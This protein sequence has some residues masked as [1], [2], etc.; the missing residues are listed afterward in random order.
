M[1]SPIRL[2]FS[3]SWSRPSRRLGSGGS[4]GSAGSCR[5]RAAAPGEFAAIA[6]AIFFLRLLSARVGWMDPLL[7]GENVALGGRL[8]L[9]IFGHLLLGMGAA[10][11]VA[12]MGAGILILFGGRRR[13]L[14]DVALRAFLPGALAAAVAAVAAL[15]L[16]HGGVVAGA[17][18]FAAAAPLAVYRPGTAAVKRL[19]LP[20]LLSGPFVLI[21]GAVLSF[22]YHG[23]TVTLSGTP[24]GDT[25]I[26]VGE[27][28]TLTQH[29]A[30]FF[31][32]AA[33]GFRLTYANA[34]P[35]LMAAPLLRLWWF[36]PYLFFSATLPVLAMATLATLLPAVARIADRHS[37]PRR[38]TAADV[39]LIGVLLFGMLRSPSMLIGSPPFV[40]VFP[41][42][43]A[44]V[45][46]SLVAGAPWTSLAVAGIGTAVSKV[47]G[48]VTLVPLSLF[49]IASRSSTRPRLAAGLCGLVLAA[50][51]GFNLLTY[52]PVFLREGNLGPTSVTYY[53]HYPP[54]TL[55]PWFYLVLRDTG[56]VLL[57]VAVTRFSSFGLRAGVWMSV[58]GFVALPFLFY[59]A[60]TVAML[61][62]A[63][64]Y[65][66]RP[67]A[68]TGVRWTMLVAAVL[69]SLPQ[70]IGWEGDN[71]AVSL[72]WGA[73]VVA[74]VLAS[75]AVRPGPGI[76]PRRSEG[77]RNG[78]ALALAAMAFLVLLL[79]GSAGGMLYAGAD[80]H[81]FTPDMRDIW[82][83]VRERT[84]PDVLIFTDQ[85]D[86]TSSRIG[87]WNDYALAARRQF[88]LVS[89]EVT[90]LRQ[91]AA[92]RRLWLSRNAA[93]LAGTLRP[94]ELAL[95]RRYDGAYAVIAAGRP[96]PPG[97]SLLYAN[98]GYALYKLPDA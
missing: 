54:A 55:F 36:D 70:T 22:T 59:S 49:A 67:S 72:S 98:A 17:L 56:A 29:L 6:V 52:L 9:S 45:Y 47:I 10:M 42:A 73:T 88:Y 69:L 11:L 18:C 14:D 20:P 40:F 78:R 57:A 86:D 90:P 79:G 66:A 81:L 82:R 21:F 50:Y 8:T 93:V 51:A 65:L 97:A 2:R 44:S 76:A 13:A 87:G 91:D 31:N 61:T 15:A 77:G 75:V 34:L 4:R 68:S 3:T 7:A 80:A 53:L 64:A 83:V 41:I 92:L 12:A 1:R 60:L 33:E 43:I 96:A 16:P 30:P 58:L 84:P 5:F 27:A 48:F 74:I 85:T 19:L 24:V 37:V 25:T 32:Y 71:W 95:S 63:T 28:E 35:S 39:L 89:W 94:S 38:L 62:V 23:P 46:L 26:Y